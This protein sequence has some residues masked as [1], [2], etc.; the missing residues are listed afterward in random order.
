MEFNQGRT[1]VMTVYFKKHFVASL[2]TTVFVNDHIFHCFYNFSHRVVQR[3]EKE[4]YNNKMYFLFYDSRPFSVYKFYE[5]IYRLQYA[6]QR[7]GERKERRWKNK[8]YGR[9]EHRN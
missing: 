7:C 1:A 8:N 4:S 2:S 3:K 9:F 5:I 6:T